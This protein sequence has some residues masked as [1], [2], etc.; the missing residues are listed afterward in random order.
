MTSG[1]KK[2]DRGAL[3]AWNLDLISGGIET[4]IKGVGEEFGFTELGI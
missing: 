3:L 2:E 1:V 4:V